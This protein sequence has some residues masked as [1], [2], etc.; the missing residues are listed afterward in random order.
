MSSNASSI[1]YNSHIRQP[2]PMLTHGSNCFEIN[3]IL[4]A[5][6]CPSEDTVPAVN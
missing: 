3:L 2:T 4:V 5:D 1:Y 6:L